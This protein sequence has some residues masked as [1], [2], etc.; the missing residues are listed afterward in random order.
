ML[1]RIVDCLQ[2]VTLVYMLV[3]IVDFLLERMLVRI[4]DY[5]LEYMLVRIVGY[6][7]VY[8]QATIPEGSR[9]TMCLL[10]PSAVVPQG[11]GL[12]LI[13]E[14]LQEHTVDPIKETF[15]EHTREATKEISQDCILDLTKVSL[16]VRMLERT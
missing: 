16:P 2:V 7:R 14:R 13:I 3:R 10:T 5:S 1:V 15:L 12:V 8:T 11:F 6:L 4:V 9:V